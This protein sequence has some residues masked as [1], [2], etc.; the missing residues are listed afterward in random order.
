MTKKE[1]A[2]LIEELENRL[3][4]LPEKQ[5]D[6]TAEADKYSKQGDHEKAGAIYNHVAEVVP[7]NQIAQNGR[8]D[9][10]AADSKK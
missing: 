5:D 10:I 3:G 6:Y 2:Q 1:H 4:H 7:G 8:L 9:A